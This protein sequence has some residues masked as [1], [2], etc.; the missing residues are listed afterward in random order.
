MK[1]FD[2]LLDT[3]N[4]AAPEDRAEIEA[5]I[6]R[7][8][9]VHRTALVLDMTDFSISV[10]R[11]GILAHLALIRR[12]QVLCE[13]PIVAAGGEVVKRD[14]DNVFAVFP[15]AAQ[16]L[17]AAEAI[18]RELAGRG[19]ETADGRSVGASI[20]IDCGDILLIRETDFFG[21]AVNVASKLGEDLAGR[22]EI[23][24]SARAW[25]EAGQPADYAAAEYT[26]SGMPIAVRRRRFD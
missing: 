13:P 26:V 23:L 7:T 1:T 4:A 12:M 9:Q 18:Q 25:E 11:T 22:G 6:R 10:R 8:F 5:L 17:R 21:D 20:G 3:L 14:A 16:A 24:L 2:H 15:T 19:L